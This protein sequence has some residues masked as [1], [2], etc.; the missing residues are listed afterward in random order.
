MRGYETVGLEEIAVRAGCHAFLDAA[1]R[2]DYLQLA[3]ID[4]PRVLGVREWQILDD[5]ATTA[6]LRQGLLEAGAARSVDS[7]STRA[8]ATIDS[9]LD[10]MFVHKPAPDT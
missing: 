3:L 2:P 4:A 9:L 5:E 8:H 10:A 6:L 7:R 1:R